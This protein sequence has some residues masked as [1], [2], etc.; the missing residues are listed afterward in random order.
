MDAVRNGHLPVA[1]LLLEKHQ[2][3]PVAADILGAKPVHQV[4]VTGQE[5]ALRFLVLDLGVDIN[6]RGTDIQ[7]TALHY[8]AKEGHVAIIKTLVELGADLHAWDKKGRTALHM[9]CIGQQAEAVRTLLL[10]GLE[11]SQDASGTT[12]RQLAMKQDVV[13][14]FECGMPKTSDR[15]SL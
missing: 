4:A 3:S 5:E 1:K 11:D 14:M 9:A 7:L 15:G 2:A 6:Q 8:A 13:R 10:L 12:A